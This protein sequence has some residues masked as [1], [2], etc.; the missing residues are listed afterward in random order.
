MISYIGEGWNVAQLG[1][2]L[3]CLT[4]QLYLQNI[5]TNA[6][7]HLS[8]FNICST[9][10]QAQDCKIRPPFRVWQSTYIQ[11]RT[12]PLM[13][14]HHLFK[15]NNCNFR[16]KNAILQVHL[17]QV[18]NLSS[19]KLKFT[20]AKW[21]FADDQVIKAVQQLSIG[22]RQ[23][24]CFKE[25]RT[26]EVVLCRNILVARSLKIREVTTDHSDN[27][28]IS[29]ELIKVP[30]ANVHL[31]PSFTYIPDLILYVELWGKHNR[32]F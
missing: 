23:L 21:I 32:F 4:A 28:Q 20:T 2:W 22:Q 6:S 3:L 31:Q 12:V 27:F 8:N 9:N 15:P 29:A 16:G 1:N 7:I 30:W 24:D 14:L 11:L 17:K 25:L 13:F 26:A 18:K 5:C 19:L 10:T